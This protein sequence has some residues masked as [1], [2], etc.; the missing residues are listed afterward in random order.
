MQYLHTGLI[1]DI[2]MGISR[3][4]DGRNVCRNKSIFSDL[5]HLKVEKFN[6][7]NL[8]LTKVVRRKVSIMGIFHDFTAGAISEIEICMG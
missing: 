4:L 3:W 8:S 1:N 2:T 6:L 7:E 5:R